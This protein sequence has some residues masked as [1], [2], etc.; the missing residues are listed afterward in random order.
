M[1]RGMRFKFRVLVLCF[2]SFLF[3]LLHL[4]VNSIF[5]QQKTYVLQEDPSQLPLKSLKDIHNFQTTFDDYSLR[6]M[7]YD[8]FG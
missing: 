5:F 8:H 6:G 4:K 7:T 2:L 1:G 3:I